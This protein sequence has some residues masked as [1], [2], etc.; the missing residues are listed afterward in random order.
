LVIDWQYS[1]RSDLSWMP[2]VVTIELILLDMP[3]LL[4]LAAPSKH[5]SLKGREHGRTI[6]LNCGAVAETPC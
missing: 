1:T 4:S 6:P 2:I 5:H 3:V